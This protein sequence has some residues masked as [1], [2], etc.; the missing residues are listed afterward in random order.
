MSRD[1]QMTRLD[2]LALG[3]P[4]AEF[5]AEEPGPVEEVFSFRR[6][7]GGDTSNLL[8]AAARLGARCGY[9]TRVGEDAFGE[10]FLSLWSK[11][12]IDTA[13][14]VIDRNSFTGIYFVT[15]DVDGERDFVYYR[16]E[17]AA[18]RL[19]PQD[20]QLDYLSRGRVFHVSGITQAISKSAERTADHALELANDAGLIVS[21]DAN[22][23]PTLRPLPDLLE[24]FERS[25]PRIHILFLSEH[26]AE[27][28][29]PDMG[30]ESVLVRLLS[31]G[32][33][34]VA[35]TRGQRG[36]VVMTQK[37]SMYDVPAYEV[38]PVDTTGAG[39]AWAAGFLV[40][41]LSGASPEK[42]ARFANAVG[43]LASTGLG[44]VSGLPNRE[45]VNRF[46]G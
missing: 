1:D 5:A 43:A 35:L 8:I 18:S 22:I 19:L 6:G 4:L 9:I 46:L 26:D 40:E 44:A 25:L 24:M 41:W 36:C 42:A 7:W 30:I 12:G 21:Y 11:E 32:P 27:L 39:D 3:E 28:L 14:V 23:R 29:Y 38:K 15:M 45:E 37:G 2:I 34:L 16:R 20:V 17:S 33:R 10:S 13:G 31:C